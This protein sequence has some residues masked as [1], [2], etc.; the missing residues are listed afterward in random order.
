MGVIAQKIN[1]SIQF[2]WAVQGWKTT[3]EGEFCNCVFGGSTQGSEKNGYQGFWQRGH[4]LPIK[5]EI[6]P[7]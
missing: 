2:P 3:G 6:G 5:W 1:E 4:L 7:Y